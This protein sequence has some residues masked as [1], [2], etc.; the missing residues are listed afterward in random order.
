MITID[1]RGAGQGKTTDPVTG[2]YKR[3]RDINSQSNDKIII[4]SPS[5]I[6]QDQYHSDL[7]PINVTVVNSEDASVASQLPKALK[8]SNIITITSQSFKMYKISEPAHLIIDECITPIIKTQ[9]RTLWFP[10]EIGMKKIENLFTIEPSVL[11]GWVTLRLTEVARK[12]QTALSKEIDG[13][14]TIDDDL[15]YTL[16]KLSEFGEFIAGYRVK[17]VTIDVMKVLKPEFLEQ[18]KSIHFA[19]A[20]FDYTLTRVWL[21]LHKKDYTVINEFAEHIM[22]PGQLKIHY[23]TQDFSKNRY[24]TDSKLTRFFQN[25]TE[26]INE[27]YIYLA[28]S[29]VKLN[30]T[31]TQIQHNAHGLNSYRHITTALILSTINVGNTMLEF[32]NTIVG[33][34]IGIVVTETYQHYQFIMRTN[35]RTNERKPCNII[36]PSKRAAHYLTLFFKNAELIE[37]NEYDTSKKVSTEV[38]MHRAKEYLKASNQRSKEVPGYADYRL[39][40]NMTLLKKQKDNTYK[41]I[42]LDE[43]KRVQLMKNGKRDKTLSV[44]ELYKITFGDN[45]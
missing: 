10:E 18:W 24:E 23:T 39:T 14:D 26:N 8:S 2:I 9:L 32:I 45:K 36:V 30:L 38:L 4:V 11:E 40:D 19:G 7:L 13:I 20:A 25:Y 3:I 17:S 31:G 27:D 37:I 43:N 29:G 28:N 16:V 22:A 35:L 21:D 15:Y 42:K 6:L 1:S 33:E 34:D 5:K 12:Y 44:N 41:G